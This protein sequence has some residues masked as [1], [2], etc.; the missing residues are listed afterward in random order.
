[1]LSNISDII[2]SQLDTTGG[3]VLF[4]I[5]AA[6]VFGSGYYLLIYSKN[7]SSEPRSRKP[8]LNTIYKLMIRSMFVLTAIVAVI[9]LQVIF[10]SEYY[11]P[12]IVTATLFS[13]IL[14][15]A[16][17][18]LLGYYLFRWFMLNKKS[19]MVA[20]FAVSAFM[21][22]AALASMGISQGGL[23]LAAGPLVIHRHE[24]INHPN[25][26]PELT[27]MLGSLLSVGYIEGI[28]SYALTWGAASIL[29][30]HYSNR[31]GMKKYLILV[32]V[33]MGAFVIG[34]T[35]PFASYNEHLF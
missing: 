35:P 31:I 7:V 26:N 22:A 16:I 25:I 33:P 11:I 28:L 32:I 12:L 5:L 9:S 3:V 10:L 2:S 13:Y 30:Y 27:G 34:I 4:V 21:T 20:L 6:L 15:G 24:S 23:F 8:S 19:I 1:M 18:A 14:A 29:L 17:M